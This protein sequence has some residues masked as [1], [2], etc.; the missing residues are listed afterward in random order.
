MS[1]N[2]DSLHIIDLIDENK[3]ELEELK[4][5]LTD[6]LESRLDEFSPSSIATSSLPSFD[7]LV[8]AVLSHEGAPGKYE[9]QGP[10]TSSFQELRN[11]KK[12]NFLTLLVQKIYIFIL[13]MTNYVFYLFY[14]S[15]INLLE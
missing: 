11:K 3:L 12:I 14:R 2:Q 7:T 6:S 4:S 15:K 5:S 10:P 1:K 8:K 13:T 9:C